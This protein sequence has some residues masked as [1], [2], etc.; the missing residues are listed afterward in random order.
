MRTG[1]ET[2]IKY[3]EA[4]FASGLSQAEFCREA[5]ICYS[6]FNI[7]K[8]RLSAAQALNAPVPGARVSVLEVSGLFSKVC[9][10]LRILAG[11]GLVIEIEPGFCSQTLREVLAVVR[12]GC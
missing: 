2:W 5:G 4:W 1:R 6:S 7:W 8:R 11:Q 9:R 10:P 3:V 12:D